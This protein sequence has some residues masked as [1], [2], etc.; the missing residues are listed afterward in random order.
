MTR[1]RSEGAAWWGLVPAAGVGRRLGAPIPKQYLEI[2]GHKVIDL[3]LATL[4][5]H[6][7]V[8]GLVVALDPADTLWPTTRYAADPRV[9]TVAGGAERAHSVRNALTGLADRA[10]RGRLGPGP[11]RRPALSA[12]GGSRPAHGRPGGGSGGRPPRRPG[13]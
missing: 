10:G 4:L 1:A 8:R 3:A 12:P 11:R 2:D 13:A 7:K 6:P 5:D 9:L